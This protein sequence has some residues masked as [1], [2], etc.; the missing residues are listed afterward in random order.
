MLSWMPCGLKSYNFPASKDSY[1]TGF[2][3]V[4]D[5]LVKGQR[6][7]PSES[8]V[9]DTLQRPTLLLVYTPFI[10]IHQGVEIFRLHWKICKTRC[11][12]TNR[13]IYVVVAVMVS[14]NLPSH[15]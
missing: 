2:M 6:C 3:F 13:G 10:D 8:A 12:A 15:V 14:S 11:K 9:L 4:S 7:Q 1:D 5:L